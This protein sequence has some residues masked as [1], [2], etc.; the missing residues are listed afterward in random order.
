MI[1]FSSLQCNS[2]ELQ[3]HK[4]FFSQ[5]KSAFGGI[6]AL[7]P[8][9]SFVGRPHHINLSLLHRDLILSFYLML[10]IEYREGISHEMNCALSADRVLT[11]E[12][13]IQCF[14]WKF[15]SES[16]ILFCFLLVHVAVP[17]IFVYSVMMKWNLR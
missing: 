7:Q 17:I 8:G 5:I 2:I 10:C 16:N 1:S 11:H 13:I 9:K 12:A 14:H 3:L 15:L 4:G 6:P